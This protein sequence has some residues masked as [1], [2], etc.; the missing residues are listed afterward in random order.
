MPEDGVSR[1]DMAGV[2][3]LDQLARIPISVA[4]MHQLPYDGRA[5]AMLHDSLNECPIAASGIK[6]M[7]EDSG[8][9]TS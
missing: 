5:R 1:E 6:Q 4:H 2:R 3:N 7:G 8:N 9:E